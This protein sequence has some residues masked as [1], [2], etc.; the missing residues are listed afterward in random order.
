MP[1]NIVSI[2]YRLQYILSPNYIV[3]KLYRLH[4]NDVFRYHVLHVLDTSGDVKQSSDTKAKEVDTNP[5]TTGDVKEKSRGTK[6][7]V[8]KSL[9]IPAVWITCTCLPMLAWFF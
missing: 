3:S 4:I 6:V 1:P 8:L 2:L 5:S 9:K 7:T